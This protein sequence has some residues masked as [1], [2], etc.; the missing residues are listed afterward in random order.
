MSPQIG[1]IEQSGLLRRDTE[2][3]CTHCG[4]QGTIAFVARGTPR[5]HVTA[6]FCRRCWPDAHLRTLSARDAEHAAFAEAYARWAATGD[7][8]EPVSPPGWSIAWHWSVLP[9]SLY[10]ESRHAAST[11]LRQATP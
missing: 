1:W 10:R 6:R 7:A 8:P 9:S 11:S 4:R 5:P 2:A 3:L